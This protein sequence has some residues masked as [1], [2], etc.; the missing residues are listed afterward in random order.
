MIVNVSQEQLSFLFPEKDSFFEMGYMILEQA[1]IS[2]MLPYQ[3][4]SLANGEKLLFRIENYVPLS[5]ALLGFKENQIIDML[6]DVIFMTQRV[7]AN[8]FMKKECIWFSY[9]NIYYDALSCKP[10]FA[11][12]PITREF[13]YADGEKWQKVFVQTL[14]HIMEF[15]SQEKKNNAKQLLACMI[16][17]KISI[18]MLLEEIAQMGKGRMEMTKSDRTEETKL[19]LIYSGAQGAFRFM[20]EEEDFII[21]RNEEAVDGV[22]SFSNK[23]SRKHCLITKINHNYFVQDLDSTNCTYV[24]GTR[25]PPYELM[26][27]EQN[28]LLSL[29]DV[30]IRVKLEKK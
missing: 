28:D 10:L 5:E 8:G 18:S 20:I 23:I 1:K 7:E 21:G 3:R 11:V 9:E 12:L 14:H 16:D 30:D 29:A 15:L 4:I 6:Y 19:E 24:N 2:G 22:I 27:L 13:R 17:G 25:I 26:Q